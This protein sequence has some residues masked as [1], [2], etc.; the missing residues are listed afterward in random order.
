MAYQR[1]PKP[2]AE[3][4]PEP[5]PEPLRSITVSDPHLAGIELEIWPWQEPGVVTFRVRVRGSSLELTGQLTAYAAGEVG[6]RLIRAAE[7]PS[8]APKGE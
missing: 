7:P 1:K 2:Q 3:S 5:E 4:Q 8:P 6:R